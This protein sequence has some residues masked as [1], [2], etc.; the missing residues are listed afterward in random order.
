MKRDSVQTHSA[1]MLA[2][3]MVQLVTRT[4]QFFWVFSAAKMTKCVL[5]N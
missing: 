2:T 5:T 3:T 1:E 4:V